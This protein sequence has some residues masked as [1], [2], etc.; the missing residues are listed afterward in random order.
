MQK[1]YV[2]SPNVFIIPA[3]VAAYN[4]SE[5]WLDQ[6]TSYIDGNFD[7]FNDFMNK[8]FRNVDVMKVDA[9]YLA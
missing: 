5:E 1:V 3:V 4:E 7:C 2:T 9:S 6:L 8:N